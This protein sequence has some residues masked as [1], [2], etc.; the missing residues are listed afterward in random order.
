MTVSAQNLCREE[1]KEN[2]MGT[3]EYTEIDFG[4]KFNSDAKDSY[5]GKL[6]KYNFGDEE[7]KE[8]G[9]TMSRKSSVMSNEALRQ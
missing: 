5:R 7:E 9:G 8:N 6:G 4:K 3:S 2:A 1:L